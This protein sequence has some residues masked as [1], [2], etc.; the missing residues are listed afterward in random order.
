MFSQIPTKR[1]RTPESSDDL[2]TTTDGQPLMSIRR[3]GKD[4]IGL[5]TPPPSSPI[6][7]SPADAHL[8]SATPDQSSSVLLTCPRPLLREVYLKSIRERF[9]NIDIT[10]LNDFDI[11]TLAGISYDD[12]P[13]NIQE[14]LDCEFRNAAQFMGNE[15]RVLDVS[16]LALDAEADITGVSSLLIIFAFGRLA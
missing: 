6:W 9:P 8:L 10:Y 12:A 11:L 14:W 7:P 2:D 5:H 4:A 3:T 13:D 16:Q 15:K 1:V